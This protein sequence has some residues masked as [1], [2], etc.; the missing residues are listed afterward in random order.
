MKQVFWIIVAGLLIAGCGKKEE[1]APV[2]PAPEVP[3]AVE[4]A[5]P[6]APAPASTAPALTETAKQVAQQATGKYAAL[7]NAFQGADASMLATVQKA[8]A[9]LEGGKWSEAI[10]LLQQLL[11]GNLT[12]EQKQAV[13]GTL[14]DAQKEAAGSAVNQATQGAAK[15]AEDVKKSLPFGQ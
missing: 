11:A 3:R 10:P 9:A 2:A 4:P 7:L 6:A 12:A 8:V 15:S 1:P 13:Q 5:Q 14:A